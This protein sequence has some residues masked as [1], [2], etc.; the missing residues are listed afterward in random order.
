EFPIYHRSSL[1]KKSIKKSK[2]GEST[3]AN[4]VG[5]WKGGTLSLNPGSDEIIKRNS[6]SVKRCDFPIVIYCK[7]TI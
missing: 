5:I 1:L 7:N 2:I 6:C 3:G 4:I